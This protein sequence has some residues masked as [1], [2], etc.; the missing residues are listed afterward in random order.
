MDGRETTPFYEWGFFFNKEAAGSRG[1]FWRGKQPNAAPKGAAFGEREEKKIDEKSQVRAA[2]AF[3]K[4]SKAS[5]R[6][7]MELE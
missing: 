2:R 7:A 3:S 5:F 6:F 1:R 4:R